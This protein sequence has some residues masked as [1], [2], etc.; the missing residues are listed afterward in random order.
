[1]K[2]SIAISKLNLIIFNIFYV[3]EVF[4][5]LT[6]SNSH[7]KRLCLLLG[8][9]FSKGS[10]PFLPISPMA[11]HAADISVAWGCSFLGSNW[12]IIMLMVSLNSFKFWI[13]FA[14]GEKVFAKDSMAPCWYSNC[15]SLKPRAKSW[16]HPTYSGLE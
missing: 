2:I 4:E 9:S 15:F 16:I 6:I 8:P 12:S 10:A 5:D 11:K 13:S 3:I 1:M 14:F 7:L